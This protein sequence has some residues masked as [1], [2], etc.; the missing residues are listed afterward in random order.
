MNDS[1]PRAAPPGR[2]V[3]Y[4]AARRLRG[5]RRYP[6]RPLSTPYRATSSASARIPTRC[7]VTT[8]ASPSAAVVGP[9]SSMTNPFP[10]GFVQP[11]RSSLRHPRIGS[12]LHLLSARLSPA[13]QQRWRAGLQHQ[14]RRD[15]VAEVAYEGSYAWIPQAIAGYTNQPMDYVPAA[16]LLHRCRPKHRLRH[17]PDPER[18]ESVLHRQPGYA[19]AIEPDAL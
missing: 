1:L 3:R 14:F 17:E 11:Y 2:S 13:R 10:N 5:V 9:P 4:R 19:E 18:G 15:M 12:E 7:P 6:Q 8:T 16:I